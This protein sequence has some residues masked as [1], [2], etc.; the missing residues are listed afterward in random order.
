MESPGSYSAFIM[1]VTLTL[2]GA[3]FGNRMQAFALYK[4]ATIVLLI[5]AGGTVSTTAL[6]YQQN[7]QL[8]TKVSTLT[9]S[10]NSTQNQVTTLSGQIAQVQNV[11]SQLLTTNTQINSQLG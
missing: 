7:T 3:R 6:Y 11:N 5:I 4:V 8:N 1:T 9:A 2:T 10:L